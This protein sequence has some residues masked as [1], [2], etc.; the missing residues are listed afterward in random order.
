MK[1]STKDAVQLR[2][3]LAVFLFAMGCSWMMWDQN[4]TAKKKQDFY[5]LRNAVYDTI[6]HHVTQKGGKNVMVHDVKELSYDSSHAVFATKYT[7]DTKVAEGE[8]AKTNVETKIIINKV[9]NVWT[10]A[11]LDGFKQSIQ[12]LTGT[13]VR[14][15]AASK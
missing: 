1:Q 9:N 8:V 4:Q 3:A 15:T 2:I 13:V 14:K 7:F 10:I 11:K 12:Y 5:D 6:E